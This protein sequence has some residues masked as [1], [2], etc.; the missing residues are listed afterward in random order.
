MGET[1]EAAAA[2]LPGELNH[3]VT[4]STIT[5][6]TAIDYVDFRLSSLGLNVEPLKQWRNGFAERPSFQQ[7]APQLELT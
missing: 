1:I 5:A 7:T 6:V 4:L 3:E 2:A